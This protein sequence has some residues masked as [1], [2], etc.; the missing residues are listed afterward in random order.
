MLLLGAVSFGVGLGFVLR[1]AW[2]VTPF[3][4]L[5]VLLVYIAFRFEPIRRETALEKVFP[6]AVNGA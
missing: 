6:F 5:D 4:G 1:G 3:F 2:P